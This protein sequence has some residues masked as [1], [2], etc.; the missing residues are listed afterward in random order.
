MDPRSLEP[1]LGLLKLAGVSAYADANFSVTFAPEKEAV[2]ADEVKPIH[3]GKVLEE[4]DGRL[5]VAPVDA[6]R[7]AYERAF[8]GKVPTLFKGAE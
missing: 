7:G 3:R 1:I 4:V 8:G 5:Q 6:R 2:R